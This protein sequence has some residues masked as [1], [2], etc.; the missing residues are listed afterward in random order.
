M[1]AFTMLEGT[2][3]L[4]LSDRFDYT[5]WGLGWYFAYVGLFIMVGQGWLM[6]RL[7]RAYGEWAVTIAGSTLVVVG[8]GLYLVTGAHPL[9]ALLLLAG[10]VNA[11]GRS[12]QQPPIMTLV[13]KF[14]HRSQQGTAF[15]LYHGLS[16]LA[17]SLGPVIAGYT[18]ARLG[19]SMAAPFVLAGAI[20]AVVAVWLF[21]L[22]N[23]RAAP[24]GGPPVVPVEAGAAVEGE[25]ETAQAPS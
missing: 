3:G 12:L 10:T 24:A 1:T 21:Q 23:T 11:L 19:R 8:M 18:L 2:I 22:R 17:R 4:Y 5:A 7:V 20:M 25:I 9:L 13:S 15:G 16:S 14:T 6:A